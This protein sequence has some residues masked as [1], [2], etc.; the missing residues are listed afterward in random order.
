MRRRS[1][2]V[3][4]ILISNLVSAKLFNI[5]VATKYYLVTQLEGGG[6]VDYIFQC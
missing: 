3:L 1:C 2:G 5:R 4:E 6:E